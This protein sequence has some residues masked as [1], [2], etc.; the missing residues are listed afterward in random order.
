[1]RAVLPAAIALALALAGCPTDDDGP[2]YSWAE[3]VGLSEPPDVTTE[4]LCPEAADPH[5]AAEKIQIDCAL[6]G[7]NFGL[8]DAGSGPDELLVMS[9]NLERGLDLDEQIDAF[10]HDPDLPIP[11]VLLAGELDRGCSRT[12]HRNVPWELA[13]AL[14]MHYVFAVE[15]LELPRT[16]GGGGAIDE[17]CEHGNAVLSR[18]PIG[19]VGQLRHASQCSWY[20]PP[21]EIDDD[22]EPRLGGRTAAHADVKVGGRYVHVYSVHF[23]SILACLDEQTA[24][25]AEVAEHGLQ[26]PHQTLIGGDTNAPFYTLEL[27]AGGDYDCPVAGAFLD[28]GYVDAHAAIPAEQRATREGWI[29]DLIFGSE[30]SFSDPVVCPEEFCGQLSDHQ[31]VWATVSL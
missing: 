8:A 23:E 27:T 12:D 11:D 5:T 28:R 2:D 15:F 1:M 30:D 21:E 17:I 7:A 4:R 20:L 26:R 9:W 3:F 6:E 16:G 13:E 10:L 14:G 25:A 29:I 22:C 19:N 31:A 24:Q 18:Y